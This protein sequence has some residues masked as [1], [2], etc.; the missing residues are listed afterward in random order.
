MAFVATMHAPVDVEPT[1]AAGSNDALASRG[2]ALFDS[3]QVGCAGCHAP[4]HKFTDATRHDVGSADAPRHGPANPFL[5][6]SG[7]DS[8]GGFDTPSLRFVGGTAP[9][10]HDGR[11]ATLRDVLVG[12]DGKMGHVAQLSPQDFAALEAY[13]LT[14]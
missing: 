11:Y 3:Q 10:F 2:R 5:A 13:L 8:A 14:L 4:D 9:Y 6:S 7:R 12:T 1:P